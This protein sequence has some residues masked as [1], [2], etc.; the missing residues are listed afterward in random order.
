M[1]LLLPFSFFLAP[2]LFYKFHRNAYLFLIF[3]CILTSFLP[4]FSGFDILEFS[5]F[6]LKSQNFTITLKNDAL[7]QQMVFL[8]NFIGICVVFY[9]QYYFEKSSFRYWLYLSLF[10]G[11]MHG[12]I[13]SHHAILIFIFWELVGVSSFLLI[14][15][16][17]EKPESVYG[18][19]KALWLNKIGDIGFLIGILGVYIQYKSFDLHIW[20]EQG[21]FPIEKTWILWFLILGALAKSAQGPFMIWL[22]DAMAGPTPASALIHAATMVAAGIYLLF[23]LQPILT[24]DIL[25][26]LS[27]LGSIT[28]L[29]GAIYAL[30]Q[31]KLKA[32]L[33]GST[34]SQLGWMLSAL[35]SS[36]PLTAIEHLWAHAFFKA[37]LF[38]TA[39]YI[40]HYQEHHLKNNEDPQDIQLMGNFYAQNPRIYF[41]F[42][43]FFAALMGLPLT[44]GYL[45]KEA[46]LSAQE[47]SFTF[48]L[49]LASI[50]FTVLYSLKVLFA[51][52]N[53]SSQSHP[54]SY[55]PPFP[56]SLPI[57]L[58]GIC[59]LFWIVSLNPF[60]LNKPLIPEVHLSITLFSMSILFISVLTFWKF[61]SI[62]LNLSSQNV[63]RF[64]GL[65]S[66]YDLWISQNFISRIEFIEAKNQLV[67][68]RFLNPLITFAKILKFFE[69]K[70][71]L[72]LIMTLK[73]LFVTGKFWGLPVSIA[74][75]FQWIDIY[76]WDFGILSLTNS[77]LK[78]G[79]MNATFHTGRIQLYLIYSMVF[80]L[81]VLLLLYGIK[82]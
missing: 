45:T 29:L 28:A 35:G 16:Y 24:S 63:S 38:L 23:R 27:W 62:I 19:S 10:L 47:F 57:Y 65:N 66:F 32:I 42:C 33:A 25:F 81:L 22:P 39:G 64:W 8:V 2:F 6:N 13:I 58:L 4:F 15:Y 54:N 50:F 52:K 1:L 26:F 59:S 79:K 56:L 40:I 68:N 9:S 48:Y 75:F 74:H 3:L 61:Q 80:I 31:K 12:L 70:V 7:T 77:I 76:I 43:L 21:S 73:K 30:Y 67:V 36:F 46:L 82:F 44:S 60:H 53:N 55:S 51:L 69:E 72:G 17:Y 11:S 41:V 18:S 71:L 37:G 14:G 20:L 34:I 78:I 5:W 49:L